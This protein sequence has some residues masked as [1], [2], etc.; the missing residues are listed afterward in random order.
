MCK[1]LA[2]LERVFNDVI[3]EDGENE[4]VVL[5]LRD[6]FKLILLGIL[7]QKQW[8]ALTDDQRHLHQRRQQSRATIESFRKVLCNLHPDNA[9]TLA[10]M[11]RRQL[12]PDQV[13]LFQR[14]VIDRV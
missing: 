13:A 2:D 4:K 7:N 14:S 6:E 1:R 11:V 12:R 10:N 8:D 9:T 3:G 5:R